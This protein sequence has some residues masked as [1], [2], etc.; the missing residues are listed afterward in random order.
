MMKPDV[1]IV[2]PIYNI[3]EEYIRNCVDGLLAQ[4]KKEI[5]LLL[6]DDGSTNNAYD[7]CLSYQQKD[8]RVRIFRQKNSGLAAARN[9]GM[10]EAIGKWVCF[11]DPDD[12]CTNDY[13]ENMYI[14]GEKYNAD[15]VQCSCY[16]YY[17]EKKIIK[18]RIY[19]AESHLLNNDEKTNLMDQIISKSLSDYYPPEINSGTVWAKLFNMDFLKRN[20]LRAVEGMVRM[21]DGIFSLYA[22]E[23]AAAVFYLDKPLCYYRK[24]LGSASFRY[25]PNIVEHFEKFYYEVE[26][27]LSKYNKSKEQFAAF[28]MKKLTSFNSYLLYYYFNPNSGKNM[29]ESKKELKTLLKQPQYN[30]ALSHIYPE[31]LNFSEKIFVYLLKIKAFDIL[32]VIVKMRSKYKL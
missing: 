15:I 12:W 17:S 4:T 19:N 23:N 18:N 32:N 24:E 27:F 28:K 31:Y 14:C 29:K 5:E 20:N 22:F 9:K 26:K 1:S 8:S 7:V 6:I 25:N 3:K 10:D 21:Q 11:V 2:L 13:I 16:V 30:E